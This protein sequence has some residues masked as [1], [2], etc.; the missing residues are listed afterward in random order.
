MKNLYVKLLL[1]IS[2]LSFSCQN[3]PSGVTESDT[4]SGAAN[5]EELNAKSFRTIGSIERM[6][7]ALDG[8]IPANA[9]I[10]VLAEGFDWTEGPVWV[11]SLKA[12]LFC[13]IPKNTV[14]KWSA[15][16]GIETYLT[17]SGYTG[18]APR[19]GE[20][21]SNGLLLSPEGKLVLCQH[22][23]RQVAVMDASLL[24]P[25]P[26]F[27]P[28]ANQYNQKKLNS[29][30]DATFNK[31][32]DLFFTDPP[33]GLE[34]NVDDPLKELSF[35]GVYCLKNNGTLMLLTDQMSRPNGIGLSPD[36]KKLYVANSDPG[37]AIWMEYIL[38]EDGTLGNGKVFYDAT[39]LVGAEKGLPDGLKV[40]RKGTIFATGPGGVWI[41]SADARPLGLIRTGEA[42]ANCALAEND[43]VLYITAD[44]YLL[45]VKL[46]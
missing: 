37:Q 35:Q 25:E 9:V 36:Q 41:F 46:G 4:S 32:G 13:D 42:T 5:S 1:I 24:R 19:G 27:V 11:D 21:G 18:D 29:P 10:E 31:L 20:T 30:N 17:P 38:N 3:N 39:H 7:P 12:L 2:L 33:Y 22:G 14:F 16:N 44:M 40:N 28:L 45:R 8:I 6:D 43:S 26:R 23:N 34:K 15:E